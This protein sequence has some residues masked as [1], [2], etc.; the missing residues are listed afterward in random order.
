MANTSTPYGLRPINLIGG[1]PYAGSFREIKLFSNNSAAMYNGDVIQLTAGVPAAVS[2]TPV[3]PIIAGTAS[4]GTAGIVGV[5]VG[6]RYVTPAT[7]QPT[8][9]QYLPA[10]AITNGYT[11]VWVRVVDD[12]D[13]LFTIQAKT[14]IGT[15]SNGIYASVGKNAPLD[16][17][18]SGSTA[19][20]NSGA[21][22]GTSTNWGN[23]ATTASLAM[24]IVDVV[25]AT[26]TDTYPD[27]VVK[28]NAGLHSY[29][30]S[31]GA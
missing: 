21:A 5:C 17:T 28:F 31:L 27:L 22:L 19:T 16:F 18:T 24:R 15:F 30:N 25:A 13:A 20:G 4:A 14:A 6:V 12:P 8:Y 7:L 3:A 11:D 2:S 10:N 29:Y 26:A 1:Q 23:V 9:A